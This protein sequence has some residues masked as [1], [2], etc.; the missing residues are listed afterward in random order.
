MSSSRTIP[1]DYN[2]FTSV[3]Y[4]IFASVLIYLSTRIFNKQKLLTENNLQV[5]VSRGTTGTVIMNG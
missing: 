5:K 2:I 3:L 1:I 4:N